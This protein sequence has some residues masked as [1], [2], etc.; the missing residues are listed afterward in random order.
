MRDILLPI[1]ARQPAVSRILLLFALLITGCA[2]WISQGTLA[3]TGVGATRIALL[4]LTL[5]AWLIAAA[6]SLSVWLAWRAGASL[7]PLALLG[8]LALPWISG[9]GP[10]AFLIWSGPLALLVWAAIGLSLAASAL[11][12]APAAFS[13]RISGA[14]AAHPERMAGIFACIIFAVSAWQV[15]PSVPGGDEPHYLII[16]QSLLED[17]DLRIENNHRQGDYHAFYAGELP[18][19]DYRRRGRNGEIYSIHAPGLPV[20]IAPAFAVAGYHG[21]VVFLIL[22]AASGTALAWRLAWMVT[23]RTDAA[24]L[25]WAAVTISASAIFHSFTVYP[26]GVGGVIALTGV[27]ALLRAERESQSGNERI[28]PWWLHGA[29]LGLLPWVHTRFAII[30]GSL[31]ALILLRLATTRN[32]AGKAVAF[33]ALPAVSA[34]AWVGFF[35]AVYGTPDPSAP[36]ANEEGSVAFIPG[37][38]AGLFFDQRFGVFAYA[39]I[40]IT[41]CFGLGVMVRAR[42]HRRLGLELLFVLIPYLLAVTHFAMWWGGT[43]APGRFF[44]PMLPWMTIPIAVCWTAVRSPA[45][46][47]TIAAALAVS[48]FASCALVFV[49]GGYLAYNVRQTYA[50]WLEWLNGGTDL[51]RGLPAW[52]RGSELLLYRDTAIWLVVFAAAWGVLRG[53]QGTRASRDRG[54][55]AALTA[56]AYAIAA[57]V[58]LSIVWTLAGAKSVQTAPAQ[59]EVLRRIG[60]ERRTLAWSL[61]DLRRVTSADVPAMLHIEPQPSTAPGGA[62]ANDRPLYQVASVPA[63][64]YRLRPHGTD[65]AG[66]LMVGI[67]RDQ[68]SL[69]SGQL[70]MLPQPI[71]V[72]FPVDVRAIVVR[73]DEQTR[74][75]MRAL[76][77]EPVSIVP[78]AS[79]LSDDYAR[80]AVQYGATTVFF[81]D[82]RSFPEP[83]AFWI[84]GERR[85]STVLQPSN[86]QST[87]SLLLRNAPV[88]NHIVLE[89]GKWREEMQLSPGEERPLHVPI[90]PTRGAALLTVSTTAGFRPSALDANSR[91]DRFLGLWIKIVQMDQ[92]RTTPPK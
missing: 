23:G 29:A 79:R 82:D 75:S 73:G 12:H 26:D 57:M 45:T 72:R 89:S 31:G 40:L 13:Q 33:L 77:I 85:A 4:P 59:L 43:S 42:A 65:P 10:A 81:L 27:W 67:G 63:G 64:V 14:M 36:Y 3:F 48:V 20:L 47:A 35:L 54:A 51:A 78:A 8:F 16:T 61:P 9:S 34:L 80:R 11:S 83:E 44:V 86:A 37:G 6:A 70:S 17:G 24:W 84:G 52:W 69:L 55:F 76:T 32:A 25:G 1:R 71:V 5:S 19:P 21:V 74:R 87:V 92:K 90:D 68:F 7:V 18:K 58:A 62:G 39:P 60:S 49:G 30:A 38:L 46:R 50:L 53:L 22:V 28:G 2:A 15:A 56:A 66:W 88:D 91:D 41:A